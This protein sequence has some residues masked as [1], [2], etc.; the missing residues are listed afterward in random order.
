MEKTTVQWIAVVIIAVLITASAVYLLTL[1]APTPPEIHIDFGAIV[2]Y[3]GGVSYYHIPVFHGMTFAID[4]INENGGIQIGDEKYLVRLV[5]YDDRTVAD[6]TVAIGHR[7]VEQDGLEFIFSAT[8]SGM[9]LAVLPYFEEKKDQVLVLPSGAG[10]KAVTDLYGGDFVFRVRASAATRGICLAKWAKDMG[11]TDVAIM[12]EKGAFRLEVHDAFMETAEDLGLNVVAEQFSEVGELEV[13]PQLTV[14]KDAEPEL[15]ILNYET[16]VGMFTDAVK[17]GFKDAGIEIMIPGTTK[18]VIEDVLGWEEVEGC[19]T[20][21]DTPIPYILEVKDPHGLDFIRR[22]EKEYG[23]IPGEG[24]VHGYDHIMLLA[25]ALEMA[26]STDLETVK[27]VLT[28]MTPDDLT[29]ITIQ[30]FSP[31]SDGKLF[32][33]G[34]AICPT[35]ISEMTEEEIVPIW[36]P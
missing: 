16:N 14:I 22:Y 34:Q 11:W 33:S 7:L 1:P 6:E 10:A 5:W 29:G 26:G 19:Y 21:E 12:T 28:E 9:T 23:V 31:C 27:N 18:R 8:T 35:V 32:S 13:K 25:K 3:T 2:D 15:A 20:S 24:E 36:A 4:E 30:E 17:M